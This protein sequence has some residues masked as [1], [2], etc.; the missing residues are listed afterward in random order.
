MKLEEIAVRRLKLRVLVVAPQTFNNLIPQE[1]QDEI[2]K[3]FCYLWPSGTVYHLLRMKHLLLKCL[4][5]TLFLLFSLHGLSLWL[6]FFFFHF[7]FP[8]HSTSEWGFSKV[9]SFSLFSFTFHSSFSASLHLSSLYV[10]TLHIF[11]AW[12]LREK[13]PQG[14]W[15]TICC[16]SWMPQTWHYWTLSWQEQDIQ[17]LR[18]TTCEHMWVQTHSYLN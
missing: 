18:A 10:S 2:S 7:S 6:I 16:I 1:L 5:V 3:D 11:L 17:G 15:G 4:F 8:S 13:S 9:G 12:A 14:L